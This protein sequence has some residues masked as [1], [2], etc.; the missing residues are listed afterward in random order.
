MRRNRKG[1][2]KEENRRKEKAYNKVKTKQEKQREENKT[3]T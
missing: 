3:I 2:G 1:R